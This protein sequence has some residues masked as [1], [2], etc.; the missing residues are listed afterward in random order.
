M[1]RQS[2]CIG[3]HDG[4]SLGNPL[5]AGYFEANGRPRVRGRLLLPR[6]GIVGSVNFLIDTGAFS[7][8]L[9][10]SDGVRLG[11]PFDDLLLPLVFEGV[12]GTHAYYR[13]T[14]V[15][16]FDDS[17]TE[18]GLRL[19]LAVAKPH[20]LVDNLDSLLGRDI[21][22]RPRMEYDFP[23]DRLELVSS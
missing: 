11:C 23:Q 6:L 12:G 17:G 16:E 10:P 13:E 15:I 2:V 8:A 4:R 1:L 3:N 22:N 21:L 18:I 5:I 20:P 9:H 7:T 14:A 19:E